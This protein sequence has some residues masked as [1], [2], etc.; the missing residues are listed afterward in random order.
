MDQEIDQE[1]KRSKDQ[2]IKLNS[3]LS[4]V[5][6]SYRH[7][8]MTKRDVI[9]LLHHYPIMP[10]LEKYIFISGSEQE[11]LHL[12]GTIPVPYKVRY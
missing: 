9:A 7:P 11:L 3:L 6:P 4:S 8:D 1:I 10:K 2:E 12:N 5:Q